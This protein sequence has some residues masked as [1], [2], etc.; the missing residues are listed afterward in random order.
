M[1][2][3]DLDFWLVKK[4]LTMMLLKRENCQGNTLKPEDKAAMKEA[5]EKPQKQLIQ[6]HCQS[7]MASKGMSPA[8]LW[9]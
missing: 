2:K 6:T 1:F 7:G 4:R 9:N 8:C 5:A 3:K